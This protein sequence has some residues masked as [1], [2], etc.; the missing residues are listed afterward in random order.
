MKRI[1]PIRAWK[2]E[3][4]RNSLSEEERALLPESPVGVV[5]LSDE[6]LLSVSGA[7][8]AGGCC[9]TCVCCTCE[10]CTCGCSTIILV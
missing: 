3:E 10:C 5:E 1:D 9:T 4:Y 6:D 7:A 8:E 2:D